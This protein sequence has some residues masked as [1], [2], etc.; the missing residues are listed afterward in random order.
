[1]TERTITI[2]RMLAAPRE[3]V[4]EAWT[5]ARHLEGWFAPKGFTL[6]SCE[7]D[8]RPDGVFR[9]CMRSPDGKDYWVRGAFREARLPERVVI[10]CTLHDEHGVPQIDELIDVKLAEED[11]QTRLDLLTKCSGR[12][13]GATRML[14]GMPKGW[15]Q[16][17]SRLQTQFNPDT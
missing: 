17:L 8:A 5:Q 7:A 13:E 15:S 9:M 11:G 3:R 14:E 10:S 2:T 12:G 1:M 4:F 6:H 16:T